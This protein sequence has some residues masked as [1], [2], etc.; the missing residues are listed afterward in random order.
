MSAIARWRHV[1][2]ARTRVISLTMADLA[3]TAVFVSILAVAAVPRFDADFWWHLYTG[4]HILSSGV[5][6]HD[7]LSFTAKGHVW[8]DHEWLSEVLL[9]GAAKLGAFRLVLDVFALV[10]TGAFLC[11]FSLMKARGVNPMFGL[12]LILF[13][14]VS[15]VASWGPRIQMISLLFAGIFC[16]LLERYRS[17]GKIRW[18]AFL[19]MGM[20][21]WSNLHGGFA[22]GLILIAAY[23]CG[24][25][26]DRVHEGMSWTQALR[27]QRPLAVALVACFAATFVNPGTYHTALYPLRFV[28]P[29]QFTNTIQESLSPNFHLVQ[30][31]PFELLLVGLITAPLVTRRRVSW[32]DVLICIAFTHLALQETRNIDLWCIVVLPIVAMYVQDAASPIAG[33][34]ARLNRP[35]RSARVPILNWVILLA[36]CAAGVSFIYRAESPKLVIAAARASAPTRAM[37]FLNR[38]PLSG[39]GFNS[40]AYGGYEIWASQGKIPVFIDSRADTVYSDGLLRDYL[41]I[42]NAQPSWHQLLSKYDIKWVFV[43]KTAPIVSVLAESAHWNRVFKGQ[44][45]IIYERR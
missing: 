6:T 16:L 19:V 29:N 22:V 7:F 15:T 37:Q 43:E 39:H 41:A 31:L 11:T 33:V 23:L 17:T 2:G 26:F 8:I 45:A 35:V 42:Y 5:P 32:I 4:M 30:L 27:R 12:V 1:E 28:T 21:L 20:T 34:L 13:A 10:I 44:E 9:Y 24:G 3:A 18:L 36:I 14:A 38:H 40:Y 25:C